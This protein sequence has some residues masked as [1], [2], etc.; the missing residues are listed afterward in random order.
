MAVGF[1]N[2]RDTRSCAK[3][4]ISRYNLT[5][6]AEIAPCSYRKDMKLLPILDRPIWSSTRRKCINKASVFNIS[7]QPEQ[8]FVSKYSAVKASG[9]HVNPTLLTGNIPC[10][11]PEF[12]GRNLLTDSNIY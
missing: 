6:D 4:N 1:R 2:Q 10:Y 12:T 7:F 8:I 5:E 11:F 3:I 9:N